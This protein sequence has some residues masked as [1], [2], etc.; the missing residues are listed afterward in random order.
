[1]QT[2]KAGAVYF[3]LVFGAGFVLGA[4]RIL[5]VVPRTSVRTAELIEAPIM[6][7]V[8]VLAAR[9]VMRKG[10]AHPLAVGLAALALLLCAEIVMAVCVRHLS[11]GEYIARRDPISGSV[12]LVL[13]GIFAVMPW[14]FAR[15]GFRKWPFRK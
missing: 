11:L 10:I 6:L 5:G 15:R 8:T 14:L 9:R 4:I 3:A 13:L 12:Y 7:A 2:F 1:M